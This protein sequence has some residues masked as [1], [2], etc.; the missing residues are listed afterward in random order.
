M[1]AVVTL[2]MGVG[3]VKV[4]GGVPSVHQDDAVIDGQARPGARSAA[5]GPCY[6]RDG[7][8]K[9]RA[10]RSVVALADSRS[11][12]ETR[13]PLGSEAAGDTAVASG[14]WYGHLHGSHDA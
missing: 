6:G 2:S 10:S 8:R 12:F 11:R 13:E 1:K 7:T 3:P 14:R 9:Y 4:V 5:R